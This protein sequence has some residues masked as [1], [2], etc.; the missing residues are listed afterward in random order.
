MK[1]FFNLGC[2][3]P[4]ITL[5]PSTSS[6]SSPLQFRRSQDFSISSYLQLDCNS[7]LSTNTKWTITNCTSTC[8]SQ[9]QMDQT[10]IKTSSEIFIPAKTLACGIYQLTLTVTMVAV[11]H[12]SSSASAYIKI[13]PSNITVNL[14]QFGTSMITRGYQQDLLLDPG[15]F[16]VDPDTTTFNASVSFNRIIKSYLS[17]YPFYSIE[18]DI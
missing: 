3:P 14:V 1:I 15:T 9:I 2:F 7:S 6:L 16:S 4:I 11:P 17:C 8:S 18:L 5:I 13:A 12:L 10:V